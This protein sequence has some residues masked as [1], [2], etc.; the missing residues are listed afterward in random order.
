MKET[1]IQ[2]I[3]EYETIII[4]RHERPDPDAY[5][6]QA[7]LGQIIKHSFPEKKVLLAGEEEESLNYLAR[8]DDISDEAYKGALVI[9]CDTANEER[10]SDQRYRTGDVVVKI[11]HH[12]N[13]EPYGDHMWVD[14]TASSTSE[15]I[16][17]LYVAGKNK[18]FRLNEEAARLLY[19]GIVGDT[20][21]FL[22]PSSTR[23]TFE[24]AKEL[25][26][27][28]FDRASLYDNMYQVPLKVAK[29]KGHLLQEMAPRESGAAVFKITQSMLEEYGV[30]TEE[31]HSF[32]GIAGDIQEIISWV[33]FIEEDDVIRVRLRSKGPVINELATQYNGGGHP[34]ASGAKVYSW[35]EA[36]ELVKDL[37]RVCQDFI[38]S[39]Q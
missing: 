32:V 30:T 36:D 24:A 27:F 25:V 21:R 18:G 37:D 12:P 4:H 34:M 31:T 19:A 6:S 15:M 23:R 5:G 33:F 20:G 39:D 8:L 38:Q 22:F 3:E 28:D 17:E 7:G 2:L 10:V 1:I 13:R 11:D 26:Q 14:P 16:Y 9:V 29:L 35:E